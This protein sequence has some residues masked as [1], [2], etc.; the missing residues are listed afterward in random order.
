MLCVW[1]KSVAVDTVIL[2]HFCPT[3]NEPAPVLHVTKYDQSQRLE[4]VAHPS[5]S[6][7]DLFLEVGLLTLVIG[8]NEM[9]SR[10]RAG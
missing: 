7:E 8:L 9:K 3:Y 10:L 6:T 4:I 2:Q 5:T 1:I